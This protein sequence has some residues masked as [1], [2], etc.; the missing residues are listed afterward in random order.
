[1]MGGPAAQAFQQRPGEAS[2]PMLGSFVFGGSYENS[3]LVE[4]VNATTPFFADRNWLAKVSWPGVMPEPFT[5]MILPEE[6]VS[7]RH[8]VSA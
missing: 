6:Q 4:E 8:F 7:M 2:C 3:A 1:M 5:P